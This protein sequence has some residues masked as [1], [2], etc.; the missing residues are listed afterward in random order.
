MRSIAS[1][2]SVDE[3]DLVEQM[4]RRTFNLVGRSRGT[5]F[6]IGDGKILTAEHNFLNSQNSKESSLE[7]R[8]FNGETIVLKPEDYELQLRQGGER[9]IEYKFGKLQSWDS[10]DAAIIKLK[11]SDLIKDFDAENSPIRDLD[12]GLKGLDPK[13]DLIVNMTSQG[14]EKKVNYFFSKVIDIDKEENRVTAASLVDGGA[15]HA[16]G[17]SGGPVFILRNKK[18]YFVGIVHSI[19][20]RNENGKSER[21]SVFKWFDLK[22][23]SDFSKPS[24]TKWSHLSIK[25]GH[26]RLAMLPDEHLNAIIKA[27]MDYS[28]ANNAGPEMSWLS[29]KDQVDRYFDYSLSEKELKGIKMALSIGIPTA[30]NQGLSTTETIET[31]RQIMTSMLTGHDIPERNCSALLKSIVDRHR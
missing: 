22:T 27:F 6:Y 28:S 26:N 4:H 18:L 11:N 12:H 15:T 29:I 31:V 25:P 2:V 1:L 5:G 23:V 21:L 9:H 10:G 19:I 20:D 7:I 16:S 8:K 17:D 13:K 3:E 30:I 24:S 14:S